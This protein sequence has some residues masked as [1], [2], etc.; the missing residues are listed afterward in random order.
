MA[1]TDSTVSIG[2]DLSQLRRELAKLP[3]LTDKAAQKMLI[4]LEKQVSKAEKVAKRS[5]KELAAAN[6]RAA[7][8]AS[9]GMERLGDTAGDADSAIAGLAGV[10]DLIDPRFGDMARGVAD[11]AGGL[12]GVTKVA[13]LSG[14]ALGAV[15]VAAAALG[16]VYLVLQHDLEEAEAAQEASRE[17]AEAATRAFGAFGSTLDSVA[18]KVALVTGQLSQLD[19]DTRKRVD[20]IER[21]GAQAARWYEKQIQKLREQKDALRAA[22]DSSEEHQAKLATV[23][24]RL[25]EMTGRLELLRD[26]TQE[27]TDTVELL[28]W[29]EQAAAEAEEDRAD[30]LDRLAARQ[31]ADRALRASMLKSLREE[32]AA[33]SALHELTVDLSDQD[34]AEAEINARLMARVA[35][36]DQIAAQVGYTAELEAAFIEAQKQAE[37]ELAQVTL[38]RHEA[39]RQAMEETHRANLARLAEIEAANR[40]MWSNAASAAS[41]FFGGIGA[42]AGEAARQAAEANAEQAEALFRFYKAASIAEIAVNAAVSI[43]KAYATLGPIGGAAATV[44]IGAMAAAQ[45]AAVLSQEPPSFGDTPGAITAS[46]RGLTAS[47]APGDYVVAAQSPA[48]LQRQAAEVGGGRGMPEVIVHP[49]P[50]YQHWGRFSRDAVRKPGALSK[51]LRDGRQ[52]GRLPR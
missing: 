18:E 30:A 14:V 3:N 5:A 43:S 6:R 4:A 17:E 7:Q 29:G 11:V 48:E 22:N 42:L 35:L 49:V 10:L 9:A 16:G 41:T 50:V 25:S 40:Q 51:A 45:T 44:G 12:E 33:R 46:D 32:E 24:N 37:E 31:T 27:A 52:V 15:G 47:F 21:Q 23:N 28:A 39:A 13:R 26:R 8:E 19:I 34:A 2:G 38:D 1:R 36:L 20:E